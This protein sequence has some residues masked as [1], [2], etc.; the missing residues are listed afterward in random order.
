MVTPEISK[1]PLKIVMGDG[2]FIGNHKAVCFTLW[3]STHNNPRY[4]DLF[5]RLDPLVRF[6]KVIFSRHRILRG[7]QYRA[8]NALS[9][10]FIYP[11]VLRYLGQRY[12]NLFTVDCCQIPAWPRHDSVVVDI[13]DPV[14][15]PT[16]AQLLNLPQV[17]AVIV[18]TEKAKTIF[19]QLG[20][21]RPIWV[22]P[23]GVSMEQSDPNRIQKIR[24][25][26]KGDRDVVVGYHAPTLTLSSDGP[27][28]AREG[29]DDLDFLFAAAEKAREV[30]PRI[31]VW[32]LGQP[33]ES[34][35]KYAADGRT[36]WIKLFGYLPL[37][38]LLNYIP[39]FDIGVYPR[40]WSPP[41]GRFSVKIAQFMASATPVVSCD[42]DE[43]F[44]LN[45][46]G[47]GVVCD[48]QDDF[49]QAL[50]GLARSA[51]RRAQLGNAGR[52]YAQAK[53]DWSVL[54]PIY[55]DILNGVNHGG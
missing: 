25:Q 4:A 38:D 33:S 52:M 16:E 15:S 47:C 2:N 40:T 54:I 30:E 51:E 55:K 34:V 17:K 14:F 32:L 7:L 44:I 39:N 21:A 41:P 19:Q 24:T 6:Y 9:R 50:V 3:F 46:A 12:E 53:L 28:R 5:P 45:E 22:I 42:L 48:S 35:K 29:Q 11:G 1:Q 23:Q 31:K 26:F 8:W 18:T 43:S 37:S 13:D 10:K 27:R 20:V 36:A 49:S